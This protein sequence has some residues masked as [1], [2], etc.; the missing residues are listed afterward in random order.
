MLRTD[1]KR[2][3]SA[4]ISGS[5]PQNTIRFGMNIGTRLQADARRWLRRTSNGM[6]AV[7]DRHAIAQAIVHDTYREDYVTNDFFYYCITKSAKSLLAI[8]HLLEKGLGEDAQIL[9]R[10]AYEN[11]LAISF[12]SANPERLDDLVDRKVGIF[13]GRYDHPLNSKGKKDRR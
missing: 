8:N 12:L 3:A 10:S 9:L 11:Y 4:N 7:V 1:R 2:H 13:T 5:S 6:C